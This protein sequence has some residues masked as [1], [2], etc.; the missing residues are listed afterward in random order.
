MLPLSSEGA[1][2][3]AEGALVEDLA[4]AVEVAAGEIPIESYS[5]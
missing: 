4:L 1:K 5:I 2:L 3:R